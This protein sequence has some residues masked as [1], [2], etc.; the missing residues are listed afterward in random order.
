VR[1]NIQSNWGGMLM[2]YGLSEVRFYTTPIYARNP[3]PAVG[4]ITDSTDIVLNWVPGRVATSHDVLFSENL[5]A[6]E[7]GSALVANTTDSW[8]DLSGLN[9]TP[10]TTYYWQVNEVNDL[11]DP[12]VYEGTVWHFTTPE[13]SFGD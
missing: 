4:S 5:E 13:T 12:P 10:G 3:L 9:L 7:D 2:S 11:A 1:V 6:I 8:M